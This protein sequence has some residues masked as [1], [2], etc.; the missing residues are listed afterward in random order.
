VWGW[1]NAS[2][3]RINKVVYFTLGLDNGTVSRH[4]PPIGLPNPYGCPA[5]SAGFVA[6]FQAL[7]NDFHAD[8][9][10]QKQV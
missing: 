8:G 10:Q 3:T 7:A 1:C 9:D 6:V 4:P 2:S 5:P